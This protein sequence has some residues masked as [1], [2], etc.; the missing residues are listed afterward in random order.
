MDLKITW[1]YTGPIGEVEL[2]KPTSNRW[3]TALMMMMISFCFFLLSLFFF[4]FP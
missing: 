2:A 1:P 3:D 4:F